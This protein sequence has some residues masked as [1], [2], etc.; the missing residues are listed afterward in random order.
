MAADAAL[1]W[2]V[3]DDDLARCRAALADSAVN[4]LAGRA[5]E[6]IYPAVLFLDLSRLLALPP[7]PAGHRAKVQQGDERCLYVTS[8][9]QETSGGLRQ[10][11]IRDQFPTV[12]AWISIWHRIFG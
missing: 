2:N 12:T 8:A 10:R 1:S 4:V 7:E 6:R 5:R 3:D 11:N 9:M